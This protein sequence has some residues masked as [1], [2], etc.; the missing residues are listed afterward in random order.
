MTD[1]KN[2]GISRI[3]R[4]KIFWKVLQHTKADKILFSFLVFVFADAALI[5]IFE[6]TITSY[7]EA[8]WYCY[9]VISTIGFGDT[10]VTGFIPK[11]L[12]VLLTCYSTLVLAI[13]T[14]VAVNSFTQIIQMRDSETMAAFLEQIER[15]PELSPEE[16]R[17]L[18]EKVKAF[19]NKR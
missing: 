7:R 5:W 8:L 3:N 9:T 13:V 16:L 2:M 10:L 15:L 11:I 12:S 14:G 4:W 18:S 6:P 19:R 17:E 1:R